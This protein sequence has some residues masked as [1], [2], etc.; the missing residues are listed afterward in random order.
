MLKTSV[1]APMA[2]AS[3]ATAARLLPRLS[4][5]HTCERLRMIHILA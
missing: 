4:T 5:R 1:T 3:I 2:E